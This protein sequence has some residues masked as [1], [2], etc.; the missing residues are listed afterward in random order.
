MLEYEFLRSL[1]EFLIVPRNNKKHWINSSS[2]Q[3]VEFMC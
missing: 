2:W 3:M 1:S